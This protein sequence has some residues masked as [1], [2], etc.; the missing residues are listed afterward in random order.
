MLLFPTRKI[1]SPLSP[2]ISPY[3]Y[4][5]VCVCVC[6]TVEVL[7]LVQGVVAAIVVV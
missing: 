4:V 2:Y 1:F 3:V 5:Y 7:I 6:V